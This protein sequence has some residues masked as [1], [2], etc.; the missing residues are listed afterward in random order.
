MSGRCLPRAFFAVA[1][2]DGMLFG[3]MALSV[4]MHIEALHR[5]ASLAGEVLAS[6]TIAVAGGALL[7][8]AAGRVAGGGRN[9]LAAGLAVSGAG[10]AVLLA[11]SAAPPMVAGAALIGAGIGLFWVASQTL[12][13]QASGRDGSEHA[14]AVHYAAY[15]LGVA[16]GSIAA[17]LVIAALRDTGVGAAAATRGSY[18]LGVAAAVAALA[19]WPP[20]RREPAGDGPRARLGAGLSPRGVAIQLPDL[21]LVAALA[22]LLPLAPI[23]L[24][25]RFHLAPFVVGI[26]VGGVQAGKI[27]G[28]LAGRALSRTSGHRR[29]ILLLLGA[30]AVSSALLAASVLAGRAALFVLVLV[31]TAFVATGAWPLIVDSALARTEPSRRPSATIAWNVCEYGVIAAATAG[32]GWILAAAGGPQLLFVLAALLL[33]AAAVCASVVLRFPV[34]VPEM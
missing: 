8:G 28:A 13:G 22:L 29:A 11:A 23:V 34:H 32:S 25:G 6:C 17:G 4:P 30:A 5:P 15:T 10:E 9:M 18:A 24:A 26:T 19:L 33:G 16:G 3:V 2:L 1:A 21:L 14:F 27:G 31:A 20:R 7:A 12:L